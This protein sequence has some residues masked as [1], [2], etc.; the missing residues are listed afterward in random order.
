MYGEDFGDNDFDNAMEEANAMEAME[1]ANAMEEAEREE[2]DINKTNERVKGRFKSS[3]GI[4]TIGEIFCKE[5]SRYANSNY[6]KEDKQQLE[7]ACKKFT[8]LTEVL[9]T[10]ENKS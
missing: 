7:T 3:K 10:S 8:F 4:C 2:R 1:E 5:M 9:D 6:T